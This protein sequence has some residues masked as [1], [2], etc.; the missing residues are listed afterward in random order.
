MHVSTSRGQRW[1]LTR[2]F[3]STVGI[4][5]VAA[6]VTLTLA[7]ATVL[8]VAGS[9]IGLVPNDG[10]IAQAMPIVTAL[11]IFFGLMSVYATG[12][13]IA[14]AG[15][16]QREPSECREVTS[17]LRTQGVRRLCFLVTSVF[18][19]ALAVSAGG[20]APWIAEACLVVASG[21]GS[22]LLVKLGRGWLR[23]ARRWSAPLFPAGLEYGGPHVRKQQLHRELGVRW[24]NPASVHDGRRLRLYRDA[25]KS[26]ATTQRYVGRVL[27]LIAGSFVA[28]ALVWYFGGRAPMNPG[29]VLVSILPASVAVAGFALMR[30]SEKYEELSI[31]YG[32]AAHD[33]KR[34]NAGRRHARHGEHFRGTKPQTSQESV[35]HP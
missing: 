6:G 13:V 21:V 15:F 5:L 33:R 20:T 35:R 7:W 18:I 34:A 16:Q 24:E 19:C 17:A 22:L 3:W 28:L 29:S 9:T 2:T 10:P 23:V 30:R 31:Q 27:E 8:Y 4:A 32:E 12:I 25:A 26:R 1:Y 14:I 11:L